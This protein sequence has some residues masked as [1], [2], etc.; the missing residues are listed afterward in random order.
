MFEGW[1]NFY[2]IVGPSAA[3]L[4][5]LMFVVVT[6]TAGRERDQTERGKH[7]YTSPIVW[8]LAVV[9]G[10]ERRGRRADDPPQAVRN[11]QRRPG[12]AR[13]CDGRA[14]RG[15]DPPARN[16]PAPTACST[17][18]GTGSSRAWSISGLGGAASMVLA[19]SSLERERGGGGADGAAAGQHP[20]RVGPGDLPRADG[21]ASGQARRGQS[22]LAKL[23]R[24]LDHRSA[25]SL[26]FEQAMRA[27][28]LLGRR[29][30]RSRRAALRQLGE[31]RVHQ[32]P[33]HA[34]AAMPGV[35]HKVVNRPGRA[36]AAPCNPCPPSRRRHSRPPP[37]PARRRAQTGPCCQGARRGNGHKPGAFRA[38][39]R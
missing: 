11:R 16:I 10:A 18:G 37:R 32:R 34:L 22:P 29:Q 39:A 19:G 7:L 13:G 24:H 8:H 36:R 26:A 28:V 23:A 27:V 25:K 35:D 9:A 31:R 3:A 5:G 17:C 15:R 30:H 20:R 1:E 2:L 33:A 4:I 38:G 12:A 6:L 14:Q 21:R